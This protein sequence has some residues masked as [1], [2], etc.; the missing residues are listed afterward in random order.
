VSIVGCDREEALQ[1]AWWRRM[2]ATLDGRVEA[3]GAVFEAKFMLPWNFSEETAAEKHM[4]QLQ[5][6]WVEITMRPTRSL[7]ASAAHGRKEVLAVGRKR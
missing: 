2:A 5:H 3:T 7:P 4:A 1:D 6:K